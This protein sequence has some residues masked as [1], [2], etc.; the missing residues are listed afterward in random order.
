[1]VKQQAECMQRLDE[2][3]AVLD[4]AKPH[5]TAAQFDEVRTR[6]DWFRQFAVCNTTLD[7][8]LW[9]FRYLRGLA[10]KLTTDPKQMKELAAAY[11]TIE[12]EAPKLFQYVPTQKFSMYRVTLGELQRPPALGNPRPLMHEIYRESLRF[13]MDSVGPDYLPPEWMKEK[14]EINVPANQLNPQRG[15]RGA[16]PPA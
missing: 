13:V 12:A 10:G 14:P 6:Y 15:R 4:E 9:R 11:D 2:M 3:Q 16:V 1:M 5:L 8:S 7:V